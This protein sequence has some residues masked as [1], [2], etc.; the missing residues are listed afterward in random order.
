MQRP[1]PP[2]PPRPTHTNATSVGGPC[3]SRRRRGAHTDTHTPGLV[4]Q[5][6][7]TSAQHSLRPPAV[8][9][10]LLLPLPG[11]SPGLGSVLVLKA[12]PQPPGA[13]K[14][15]AAEGDRHRIGRCRVLTSLPCAS[16]A[17]PQKNKLKCSSRVSFFLVDSGS[18]PKP[19]FSV[20][21]SYW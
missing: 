15:V 10:Q 5:S 4:C 8:P 13:A 6:A 11:E 3:C 12:L 2:G 14:A 1:A 16:P 20:L 7:H 19:Q 17:A 18:G 9:K 21:R